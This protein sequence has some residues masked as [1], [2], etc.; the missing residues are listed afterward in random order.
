MKDVKLIKVNALRSKI[1]PSICSKNLY[2]GTA[3]VIVFIKDIIYSPFNGNSLGVT[4]AAFRAKFRDGIAERK[5]RPDTTK[6][7]DSAG[8]RRST[9]DQDFHHRENYMDIRSG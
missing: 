1:E 8:G 9:T 2:Q 6:S 7:G 4:A 5:R 3:L